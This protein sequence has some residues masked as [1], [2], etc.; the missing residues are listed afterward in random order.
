MGV[1]LWLSRLLVVLFGAAAGE[2][3]AR[4]WKAPEPWP[5]AAPRVLLIGDSNIYGPVGDTLQSGLVASGF[6]VWRRGRPSTGLSRPDRWDWFEQARKMIDESQPSTVIVQFGGNDVLYLR[7]RGDRRRRV[8]F[9]DEPAWRTEYASR[10]H[11]FLSLLS[12]SGRH[13]YLMSPTNRGIGKAQVERVRDV[14][15]EVASELP[16][17]TFIDM[18]PL[19]SD[20]NGRWLHA[21]IDNGKRVVVR[22][23]DTV[24]FNETGGVVIGERVLTS[25]RTAGLALGDKFRPSSAERQ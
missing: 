19:T 6:A 3:Q 15:R 21:V 7:W 5:E 11:A 1:R 16:G 18:F 25:L 14:Q 22:R 9:R 2:A 23:W 13:V 17:V 4:D 10:V 24:H 20:E 8:S 12:Q